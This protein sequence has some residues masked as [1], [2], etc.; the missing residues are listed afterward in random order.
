MN[1]EKINLFQEDFDK[2]NKLINEICQDR[3]SET[4]VIPSGT[5]TMLRSLIIE[6]LDKLNN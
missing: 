2:I 5:R 6:N 4:A 3:Y 1:K